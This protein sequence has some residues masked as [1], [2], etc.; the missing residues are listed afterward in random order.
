MIVH[1]VGAVGGRS[2]WFLTGA[3]PDYPLLHLLDKSWRKLKNLGLMRK[4]TSSLLDCQARQFFTPHFLLHGDCCSPALERSRGR[5][6]L[7]QLSL[8]NPPPLSHP[9]PPSHSA[10]IECTRIECTRMECTWTECTRMYLDEP[11]L[12]GM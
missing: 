12:D 7:Q 4:V 9:R 2:S 8:S 1:G 6:P 10:C 5:Q 11:Y 3:P